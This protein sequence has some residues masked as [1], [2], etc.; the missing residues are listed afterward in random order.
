MVIADLNKTYG[1]E[2]VARSGFK[3][4]TTLDLNWQKQAEATISS[5]MPAIRSMGGTNAAL[6]AVDP[7]T[8]EIKALVGSSDWNNEQ[9]GKVNMATSPRQPGSSFKPIYYTEAIDKRLITA[10]T[11][12]KDRKKTYP[13]GYE[14]QNFDRRFRGDVTIRDALATSLNIPSLDVIEKVGVE[15]ATKTAQRMGIST[16]NEPEKY[17]LALA[18]GTAE[19]RL[20]EMTNAYAAFAN[21]GVQFERA[22][23]LRIDNKYNKK[24]Y[25]YRPKG[26]RVQSSEASY[27]ISS[28]LSDNSA[29]APLFGNSLSVGNQKVAVKTGTTDDNKDAWAIGYNPNVTVG[30]WVGNNDNTPMNAGGASAAGPIWRS[31]IQSYIGRG[32]PI[33]FPRPS[34]VV[35][36]NICQLN[37]NYQEFFIRGTVPSNTCSPKPVEEEP[38]KEEEPVEEPRQPSPPVTDDDDDDDETE[39]EPAEPTPTPTPAPSPTPTPTPT[40]TQ[41]SSGG[42]TTTPQTT[43]SQQ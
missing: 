24:V 26:K 30:V 12:M 17:G 3:I 5:R 40:P 27:I 19:T 21:Q 31:A 28:I 9:F 29:R 1:E 10:A 15:N 2:T 7:K 22:S 39:E 36:A 11:I 8:G 33:D 13:G 43:P 14:P 20:T 4:K 41:P 32:T 35:T 18:L 34:A 25:E 23:V 38:K 37:R 16:V 42:T 6:V